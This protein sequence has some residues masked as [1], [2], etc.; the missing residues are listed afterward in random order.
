MATLIYFSYLTG[1]VLLVGTIIGSIYLYKTGYKY[2]TGYRENPLKTLSNN[3][4]Y[5]SSYQIDHSL[6]KSNSIT[7]TSSYQDLALIIR[8][9]PGPHYKLSNKLAKL[10]PTDPDYLFIKEIILNSSCPTKKCSNPRCKKNL[11]MARPIYN[12]FD[13]QFCCVECRDLSTKHV[14]KHWI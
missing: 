3:N 8:G 6:L 1:P 9:E 14:I 11:D 10:K 12:A 5:M 4:I 2:K 7:K 13:V